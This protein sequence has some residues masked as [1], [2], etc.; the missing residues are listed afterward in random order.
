M[1]NS[2]SCIG[3]EFK[4]SISMEPI[5]GQTLSEIDFN[6]DVYTDRSGKH[7]TYKK[8]DCANLDNYTYVVAVDSS[9]LGA[10][11]YFIKV[12]VFIPD[13]HFLDGYRKDVSTFFSGK[14]ILP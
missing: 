11:R 1:G 8:P 7:K 5:E 6:A 10:G 2:S 4:I 13:T 9:E 3:T 12:T 14:E